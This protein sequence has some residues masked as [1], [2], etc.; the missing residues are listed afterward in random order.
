MSFAVRVGGVIYYLKALLKNQV[1][2]PRER[3]SGKCARFPMRTGNISGPI[4]R[5]D[6][7]KLFLGRSGH[8]KK[9]YEIESIAAQ[10]SCFC[11]ALIYRLSRR[12]ERGCRGG[13]LLRVLP[14]PLTCHKK[15]TQRRN[16]AC[17]LPRS[18]ELQGG[19]LW[20]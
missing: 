5:D 14:L 18:E 15:V 19:N 10:F 6:W 8:H 7:E 12:C 9:G 11:R 1:S 4:K 2:K 13:C 20:K 17:G 16:D 3:E